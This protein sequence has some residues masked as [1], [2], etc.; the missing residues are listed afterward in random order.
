MPRS[1][2]LANIRRTNCAGVKNGEGSVIPKV[3]DLL[4]VYRLAAAPVA[5]WMALQGNRDAF[6][7]LIIISIVSDLVDG[8]IARWL[9]QDL[10]FG[11]K[12]DFIAD[13]STV[14]AAILGLYVFERDVLRPELPWICLFLASYVAAAITCLAKFGGLPAY[15][16]YLSKTAALCAGPFLVWLYVVDYSRLFFLAVMSLGTLANFESLLAT[17]RLKRFRSDI[18][19]L[20]FLSPEEGDDEG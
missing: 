16:L 12:L 3:A 10:E 13:A 11:A 9:G 8:P 5:A 19:S 2:R 17:L 7:V 1:P 14:L 4:T 15:H 6:F 20:F 18:G